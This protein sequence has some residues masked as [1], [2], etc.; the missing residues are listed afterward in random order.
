MELG[1][2]TDIIRS[3][4]RKLTRMLVTSVHTVFR[5]CLAMW[6]WVSSASRQYICYINTLKHCLQ[7]VTYMPHLNSEHYANDICVVARIWCIKTQCYDFIY[8]DFSCVK[9]EQNKVNVFYT[10]LLHTLTVGSVIMYFHAVLQNTEQC[11]INVWRSDPLQLFSAF[12]VVSTQWTF[13]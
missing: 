9:S 12:Y 10:A 13:M 11:V 6:T 5:T 1:F 8:C 3:A 7:A 4:A 2:S